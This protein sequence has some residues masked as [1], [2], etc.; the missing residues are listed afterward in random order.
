VDRPPARL[1]ACPPPACRDG[2][3]RATHGQAHLRFGI[4]RDA[5]SLRGE[6]GLAAV[7]LSATLDRH[8]PLRPPS[9]APAPA[10]GA[11]I[12]PYPV[13]LRQTCVLLSQNRVRARWAFPLVSLELVC[14]L[15]ALERSSGRGL[16]LLAKQLVRQEL[17]SSSNSSRSSSGSSHPRRHLGAQQPPI[18]ASELGRTIRPASRPARAFP[19]PR[20]RCKTPAAAAATPAPTSTSSSGPTVSSAPSRLSPSRRT[21][22]SSPFLA[23]SRPYVPSCSPPPPSCSNSESVHGGER[24]PQRSKA[25]LRRG[26]GATALG[27]ALCVRAGCRRCI[28]VEPARWALPLRG[29]G[30]GTARER[31]RGAA[32]C[33]A[34]GAGA[35]RAS[36]AG[37]AARAGRA[38]GRHAG[39]Q[40]HR[41]AGTQARRQISRRHARAH[42]QRTHARTQARTQDGGRTGSG[43]RAPRAAV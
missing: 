16:G 25:R 19:R 31:R 5:A 29:Q 17:R 15:E 27:A 6:P 34:P 14:A 3:A 43:R 32:D 36:R 41:H 38:A 26:A 30:K 42:A 40:A 23:L 21:T 35:R 37:H 12:R 7:A 20:K 9:L 24:N 28:G 10:D 2:A 22:S 33:R 18:S 11:R 13:E 39:T 1:P 8:T 4:G